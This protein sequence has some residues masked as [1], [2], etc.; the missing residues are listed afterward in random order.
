MIKFKKG[1][2]LIELLVVI[3]I[4]S[5]LSGIVLAAVNSA[6]EKA[7]LAGAKQFAGQLGRVAGDMQVARWNF[8]EGAG[9]TASDFSGNAH[10]LTIGGVGSPTWTNTTPNGTGSAL[11]FNGSQYLTLTNPPKLNLSGNFT[12]SSWVYLRTQCDCMFFE[13]GNNAVNGAYLAYGIGGV[14]GFVFGADN[15]SNAP[16]SARRSDDINKWHFLTGVVSGG[17]R[18][19]Y[20]DGNL[21]SSV[22]GGINSWSNSADFVIGRSGNASRYVDAIMDDIAIF[23][24]DLTAMEIRH[25]YAEGLKKHS[26]AQR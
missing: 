13:K 17:T 18:Y 24:K 8:N 1:F 19:L 10:N 26:F 21:V 3:A 4:I 15:N 16:F 20:V 14:N 9:V 5:L 12:V 23:D 22:S 6:R 2:T 25:M 11:N 7:R